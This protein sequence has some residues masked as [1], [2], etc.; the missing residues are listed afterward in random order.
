MNVF[1]TLVSAC[2][3]VFAGHRARRDLALASSST[4]ST[5]IPKIAASALICAS[6]GLGCYWAWSSG[7]HQG[8]V[9]ASLFVLCALG[10]E[11]A[12]PISIF[13]AFDA[14]RSWRPIQGAALA[15]LGVVC[16][17]YS[18]SAQLSLV[19]M[20]RSDLVAERSAQSD[21]GTKANDRY[22]RSKLELLTL[23]TTRPKSELDA[24]I[25]GL[26]QTPGA[27]GCQAINGKVTRE[28]C[29]Q[30]A[31]LKAEAARAERRDQ[32]ERTM[33]E[34]E[35]ETAASPIVKTADPGST[36]LS[37]YL[38]LVGIDVKPNLL[39][40]LLILVG[41]LALEVGSAL[42]LVMVRA[43]SP[44]KSRVVQVVN[45]QPVQEQRSAPVVPVVQLERAGNRA[46]SETEREAVKNRIIQQLKA[47]GGKV[48]AGERGLAKKLGSSRSTMRRAL[49]GLVLAGVVAAEISRNGTLLRLVA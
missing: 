45:E 29:P 24:K 48:S 20:S 9:L 1:S 37:S 2:R 5:L 30:V 36:A 7:A 14:C 8:P 26:L 21:A 6:A 38:A 15:L 31:E 22:D 44:M 40:E 17:A 12:K 10:L 28:V 43:V 11:L 33:A 18:L 46:P 19:S 23:P 3:Y 35:K 13:A 39:T 47:S 49:Q 42:S 16:V 32:L 4:L 27:D 41:V 34:A 25:A